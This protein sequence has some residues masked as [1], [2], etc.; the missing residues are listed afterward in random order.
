MAGVTTA[1]CTSFKVEL[2]KGTHQFLQTSGHAF[3]LALVAAGCS[4]TYGAASTNYS[5]LTTDEQTDSGSNYTTGGAALTV[6][7]DPTSS[8]TTAFCDF[9]DTSWANSTISAIGALIYNV[10]ASNAAVSLHSF[11][12]TKS[13]SAGT[14]AITFP[15]ADASNAI[16]RLA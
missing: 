5:E 6:P 14:F 8:S 9:T 12:G 15:T 11:G 10:S 16:L 2:F 13:S 1:M 4:G 3:K 7:A